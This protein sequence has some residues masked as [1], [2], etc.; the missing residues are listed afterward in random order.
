MDIDQR[1]TQ[2]MLGG[3]SS[4]GRIILLGDGSEVLADSSPT[5]HNHDVDMLDQDDDEDEDR[6]LQSQVAKGS[7]SGAGRAS[8]EHGD[9]W[10][11]ITSSPR[12]IGGKSEESTRAEREGTPAPTSA[13]NEHDPEIGNRNGDEVVRKGEANS[14]PAST[15]TERSEDDVQTGGKITAATD[16]PMAP[17]NAGTSK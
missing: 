6:D 7:T 14:S 1:G 8:D 10:A 12:E 3:R 13:T 9:E 16:G 15:K 11:T 17:K 5:A 2:R 4:A